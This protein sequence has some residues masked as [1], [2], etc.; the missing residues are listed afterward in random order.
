MIPPLIMIV[1]DDQQ[2][3]A[4]FTRLLQ[5]AGYRTVTHSRGAG[6]YDLVT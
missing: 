4:L 3:L 1:N 2:V 6:A 5:H